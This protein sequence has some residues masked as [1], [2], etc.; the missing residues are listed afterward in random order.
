MTRETREM[1]EIRNS[2]E[3]GAIVRQTLPAKLLT[4]A[5]QMDRLE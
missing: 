2:E 4:P 5:T 3:R 1:Q